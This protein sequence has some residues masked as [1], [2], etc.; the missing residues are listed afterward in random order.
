[1]GEASKAEL[2]A[3]RAFGAY[4]EACGPGSF[5]ATL[6]RITAGRG[7]AATASL[8]TD[9]VIEFAERLGIDADLDR[10]ILGAMMDAFM[11][12]WSRGKAIRAGR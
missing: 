9:R 5:K 8:V 2:V 11:E 6:E 4:Y 7:G 10:E 3:A 1:M 12:G